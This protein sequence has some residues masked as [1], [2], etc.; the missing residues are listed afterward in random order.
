MLLTFGVSLH[1]RVEV[2]E[3]G[4]EFLEKIQE[5]TGLAFEIISAEEEARLA[6]AGCL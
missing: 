1:R 2:A 3:N 4:K 6:T 5:K